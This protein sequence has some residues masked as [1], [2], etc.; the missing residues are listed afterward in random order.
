M[1]AWTTYFDNLIS[2]NQIDLQKRSSR[3]LLMLMLA[4]IDGKSSVEYLN[5][6]QQDF[7]RKLVY[8]YLPSKTSENFPYYYGIL[9]ATI[10]KL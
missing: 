4:R 7:V 10:K 8:R 3:L 6:T 9:L 1:I 2:D 5:Q